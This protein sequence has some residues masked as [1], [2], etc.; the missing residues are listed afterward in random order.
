MK[1]F[2]FE[3]TWI[4]HF[5][6]AQIERSNFVK[7]KSIITSNSLLKLNIYTLLVQYSDSPVHYLI[8]HRIIERQRRLSRNF[9]KYKKKKASVR[10]SRKIVSRAR[11]NRLGRVLRISHGVRIRVIDFQTTLSFELLLAACAIISGIEWCGYITRHQSMP[12]FSFFPPPC[13]SIFLSSLP[14][15][16][17]SQAQ[18]SSGTELERVIN[19][20]TF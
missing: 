8:P 13:R 16:R 5:S 14:L 2:D 10:I 7:F 18:F 3:A 11:R 12:R 17:T 6:A 20:S 19:G 9:C 1:L 15:W 4:N